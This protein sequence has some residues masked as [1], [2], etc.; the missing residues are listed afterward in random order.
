MGSGDPSISIWPLISTHVICLQKT[1]AEVSEGQNG[2]AQ[3][4]S[5]ISLNNILTVDLFQFQYSRTDPKLT[6]LMPNTSICFFSRI[7]PAEDLWF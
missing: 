7:L 2:R 5:I 3:V 1:E 4:Y 6:V